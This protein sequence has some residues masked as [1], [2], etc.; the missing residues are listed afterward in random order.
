MIGLLP[1]MTFK[2]A[3]DYLALAAGIIIAKAV[4]TGPLAEIQNNLKKVGGQ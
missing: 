1:K 4:V 3:F 2:S